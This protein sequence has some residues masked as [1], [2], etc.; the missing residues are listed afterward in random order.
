MIK[1]T[2]ILSTPSKIHV[3]NNQFIIDRT[4]SNEI[5][6]PVEDIGVLMVENQQIIFTIPVINA[7]TENNTAVIFCNNKFMPSSMLLPLETNCVQGEMFRNQTQS[8]LPIKKNLWKQIIEHK[9]CNQSRLLDKF[10]KDG[11]SLKPLYSNVRSGDSTNREGIA[12]KLYWSS[13]FGKNFIRERNSDGINGML[14]YGYSILR[15]ATSRA[16]MGSGLLP[17]YGI[18][19]KNRYNAFPLADDVMEPYRVYVDDIILS[20]IDKGSVVL[21]T[22]M[23]KRLVNVLVA[24][25]KIG[26]IMRPLEIALSIT[27][28]SL[29]KCFGG[30]SRK[31]IYPT[32]I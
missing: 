10:G 12:A 6:I 8:S 22:E 28:S 7:L 14:N 9:I 18:Y 23:K 21:D 4:D 25:T 30:K 16:L 13:L 11:S 3:K 24:D 5:S 17:S 15:S 2:I 1:R 26:D 27:T 29:A 19:H 31:L 32:F 20:S